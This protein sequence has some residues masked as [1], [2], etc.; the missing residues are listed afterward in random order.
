M[1]E[2]Q[3]MRFD[4][5]AEGLSYTRAVERIVSET[6]LSPQDVRT[7]LAKADDLDNK[8]RRRPRS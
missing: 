4:Y 5:M 3:R 2:L 8:G 7:S 6:G 1:T